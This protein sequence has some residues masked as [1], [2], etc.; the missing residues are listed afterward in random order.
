MNDTHKVWPARKLVSGESLRY[1]ELYRF[2]WL[3]ALKADDPQHPAEDGY[4]L[5]PA[6]LPRRY[7]TLVETGEEPRGG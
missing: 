6:R 5:C 3:P 2:I 7:L 4:V 1:H